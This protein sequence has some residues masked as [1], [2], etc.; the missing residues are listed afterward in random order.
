MSV[1]DFTYIGVYGLGGGSTSTGIDEIRDQLDELGLDGFVI[2]Q[3]NAVK[4]AF[5]RSSN[6]TRKKIIFGYSMGA[7][8]AID[9]AQKLISEGYEVPLV[10]TMDPHLRR[11]QVDGVG[12]HINVWQ[13]N[14][15]MV[16]KPFFAV[17][18]VPEAD[19]YLKNILAEDIKSHGDIENTPWVQRLFIDEVEELITSQVAHPEVVTRDEAE[20]ILPPWIVEVNKHIGLHEKKNN[21]ELSEYLRS[22]GTTLGDPAQLPWCG[23][24][25]ETVFKNTL[26]GEAIPKNPYWARN[27]QH[28]GIECEPKMHSLLVL[29]RGNGGHV[30]WYVGETKT[31]YIIRGG[32]QSNR[33]TD[34]KYPKHDKHGK[35]RLIS[36]RWPRTYE[37]TRQHKI[38][39]QISEPSPL[40]A[41]HKAFFDSVRE[42]LFYGRMGQ[43]QVDGM[44]L[45][46]A[47]WFKR[48][49]LTD[50]R[51]LAYMFATTWLETDRTMQA[52]MEYGD[53]AYFTRMYGI[54]GARPDKAKRL[55]NIYAGDGAKYPGRGKPMITGRGNYEKANKYV[56]EHIGIDFVAKPSAVLQKNHSDLIMFSGMIKGWFT[57]KKLSDYFRAD[58]E[59]PIGARRIVNGTDRAD[60]IAEAYEYF[61]TALDSAFTAYRSALKASM[62]DPIVSDGVAVSDPVVTGVPRNISQ[63]TNEVLIELSISAMLELR[64]RKAIGES[65]I[66][67][68]EFITDLKNNLS[69]LHDGQTGQL[70]NIRPNL[71]T[72]KGMNPMNFLSG[73]KMYITAAITVLVG[74]SE[75]LVGLDVPG[76]ELQED[77]LTAVLGGTGF[78]A[79]AH[80]FEKLIKAF[81]N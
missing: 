63:A 36:A 10:F 69:S 65:S 3:E 58:L 6:D 80:K 5:K 33:V 22:D 66:P 25:V 2:N 47:E 57:G 19:G 61:L 28:F 32:N 39:H 4:T 64:R 62:R 34:T 71:E 78:A 35:P 77:W 21:K 31:H 73:Y 16:I 7:T 12:R 49:D 45:T 56:G 46:I 11:D 27:W 51:W 70:K 75:G 43:S 41:F 68:A 59:D 1:Q 52:I 17:N 74:L 23:D 50:E 30:G 24:L 40:V 8:D 14:N 18:P 37:A 13:P 60:D 81:A 79:L 42:P 26:P 48:P 54:K 67:K 29:T 38:I 44:K 53:R 55:G 72:I 9:I 20:E 76:V 15:L